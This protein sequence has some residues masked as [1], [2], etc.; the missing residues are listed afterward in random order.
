MSATR[1]TFQAGLDELEALLHE[2]GDVVLKMLGEAA[3]AL[4]AQDAARCNK[5]LALDDQADALYLKIERG[6]EQLLARQT[7]VAVDLRL[8]LAVLH[9]NV[10]LE[11]MGDQCV[12]IAKLT[13]LIVG[14]DISWELQNDFGEM[15]EQADKMIRVALEAFAQ[16][17]VAAAESLTDL[18]EVLDNLNRE[19]A[20]EVLAHRETPTSHEAGLRAIMIARCFERIGDNAVDIGEQTV[21]LVTGEFR[22]FTDASH[23]SG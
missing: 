12:N 22:E 23:P 10:H 4:A 21:Y 20:A 17:D 14:L 11:R 2:Q 8:V 19:V 15:A 1:S 13:R 16:R 5:V 6:V 18:D 9:N 3:H 7:P